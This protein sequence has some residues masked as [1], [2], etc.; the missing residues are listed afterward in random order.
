MDS[1]LYIIE[2]LAVTGLKR[3]TLAWDAIKYMTNFW[4]EC[5]EVDLKAN[6]L[7]L[8]AGPSKVNWNNFLNL[9]QGFVEAFHTERKK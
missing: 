6:E 4:N 2:T 7:D 9:F 5:L 3:E 1:G 8:S